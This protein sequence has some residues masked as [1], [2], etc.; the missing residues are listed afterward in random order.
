[1]PRPAVGPPCN[2]VP[3]GGWREEIRTP[4]PQSRSLGGQLKTKG[5]FPNWSQNGPRKINGLATDLQL[6]GV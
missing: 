5:N 4:D 1:M 3:G 6:F 2:S